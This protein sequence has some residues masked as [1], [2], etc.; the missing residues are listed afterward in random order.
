MIQDRGPV[1]KQAET[2]LWPKENP[3][4]LEQGRITFQPH[5]YF[6]ENPIKQA[7]VYWLRATMHA[8]SDENCSKI[9][10]AIKPSMGPQ[11]R[12]LL[13][14]VHRPYLLLALKT[15]RNVL[16]LNS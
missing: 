15:F 5:T 2:E 7:A 16:T 1:L 6:A 12:I 11:S 4:A 3:R 10:A 9:L 14:F 13:W 8:M